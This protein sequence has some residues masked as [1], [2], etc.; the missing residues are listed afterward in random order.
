MKR[1]TLFLALFLTG[2]VFSASLFAGGKAELGIT[3]RTGALVEEIQI[4]ETETGNVSSIYCALENNAST[5]IKIKRDVYY[6]IT[7]VDSNRHI[8]GITKRRW[9]IDNN[10]LEISHSNYIYQGLGGL[11][12]RMFGR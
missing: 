7:L 6:D 5:V 1:M 3:N 4:K 8:Y 9:S 10:T 12:R 2:A 11:L